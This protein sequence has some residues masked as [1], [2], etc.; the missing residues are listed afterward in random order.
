MES[1]SFDKAYVDYKHLYALHQRGVFWVTRAKDNMQ[2]RVVKKLK[3]TKDP[4][5]IRDDIVVLSLPRSRRQYPERSR[6]VIAVVEVEGEDVEMTFIT[7][8][9]KWSARSIAELYRCRWDIEVF[10]KQIKQTLQLADFLGQ[11]AN[12]VRWQIWAGLLVHLILR[13]LAFIQRWSHS[14]TRM[15]TI[16]RAVLWRKWHLYNLLKSYGTAGS[17]YRM[18]GAPEQ[19]YLPGFESFAAISMG[20]PMSKNT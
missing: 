20:Q 10:F 11:N 6:R 3:T 12:A 4:R 7:N 17:S 5:I 14:F 13:Y 1:D 8:N 16:L 2:V 19:A 9:P 15:F 18:L